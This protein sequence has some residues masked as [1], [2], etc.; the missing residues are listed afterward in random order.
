MGWKIFTKIM[1]KARFRLTLRALA[2]IIIR[3]EIDFQK[4]CENAGK[5]GSD[6][7]AMDARGFGPEGRVR[8]VAREMERIFP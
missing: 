4:R 2:V 6:E 8:K 5:D 7:R 1:K 3:G